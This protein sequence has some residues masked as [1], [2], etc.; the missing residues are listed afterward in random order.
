M[1]EVHFNRINQSD[2]DMLC[3]WVKEDEILETVRDCGGSKS[4]G[5]D[6][7]NFNFIKNYWNVLGVDLI[8]ALQ[9][10][11]VTEYIPRECNAS[12]VTLVPKCVNPS[13]L[14]DFK[15]ISL[16]RCAIK[17]LLKS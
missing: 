14:G 11:Y 6:G 16:V 1:D 15:P 13:K 17:F 3:S 4:S 9:W 8:K 12:F 10:F 7:F 2:N 5:L